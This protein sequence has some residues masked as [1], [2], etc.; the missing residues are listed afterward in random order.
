MANFLFWSDLHCDFAPFAIPIPGQDGAPKRGEIDAV[1]VAGDID[2]KGA[3]I[4]WLERIWRIWELPVLAVAGNH[5]PYGAKRFQKHHDQERSRIAE[6][7]AA[8]VDVDVLRGATRVIG[9]TRVIG[10]TLWTD[11]ALNGYPALDALSIK[12]VMNDYRRV[13]WF[14]ERNGIYRKMIPADTIGMHRAELAYILSELEKP[15]DGRTM[16]M[17]HH[18][19]VMQVINPARLAKGETVTAA[20][21]SDLWP[22]LGY[23]RI[24]AWIS[25]HS[26]DA[27]EANLSGAEGETAFLSNIR[28]YPHER[29]RFE[30]HRVLDSNAPL[31]GSTLDPDVSFQFEVDN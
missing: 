26:H 3:H 7:K 25:G 5:E 9:D 13:R 11:M 21:A 6:L 14:D 4:E 12:D 18:C 22:R 24:D 19:P 15:F 2:V 16:V 8:G 20:Y 23:F 17:T 27:I 31:K 30:P 29:T 10:A 28:G 1:L